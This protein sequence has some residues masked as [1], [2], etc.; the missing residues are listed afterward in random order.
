MEKETD[1]QYTVSNPVTDQWLAKNLDNCKLEWV[2][3]TPID[4]NYQTSF[5]ETEIRQIN[6]AL[7]GYAKKE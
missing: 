7:M 6:P 4:S 1:V 3:L 5:T 2:R